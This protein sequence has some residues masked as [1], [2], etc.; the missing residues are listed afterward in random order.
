ML[1]HLSHKYKEESEEDDISPPSLNHL[2]N[3]QLDTQSL[4]L[5]NLPSQQ[6]LL[7]VL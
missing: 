7:P 3:P 4:S 1:L 5:Y 6:L 2:P